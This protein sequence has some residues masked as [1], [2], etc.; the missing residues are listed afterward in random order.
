[1]ITR[2][3]SP[4]ALMCTY[5]ARTPGYLCR[6]LAGCLPIMVILSIG[7]RV[8]AVAA[9]VV[10]A[11][12]VAVATRAAVAATAASRA[13]ATAAA[14]VSSRNAGLCGCRCPQLAVF[15]QL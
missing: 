6:R 12:T 8:A 15:Q 4:I 9:A 13:A 11:A 14:A 2:P 3:Y 1:M 5:D 7:C 10:A